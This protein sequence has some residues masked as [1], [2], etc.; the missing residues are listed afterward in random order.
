M[1]EQISLY[2]LWVIFKKRF[3]VFGFI[4]IL[5]VVAGQIYSY[6]MPDVF[7]TQSTIFPIEDGAEGM[8]MGAMGAVA[9]LA[10]LPMGTASNK[11]QKMVLHLNS[12]TFAK[13]MVTKFDLYT[14]F[15]SGQNSNTLTDKEKIKTA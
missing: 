5:S 10:G 2:E 13:R 7:R 14:F 4:F 11:L 6:I 8:G 15:F 3:W 12:P 1:K 9:Q